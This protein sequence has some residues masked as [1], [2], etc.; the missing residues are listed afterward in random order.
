MNQH[1]MKLIR[2]VGMLTLLAA[3]SVLSGPVLVQGAAEES[4]T[5]LEEVTVSASRLRQ[6]TGYE[7]PTPVT[8]LT[9]QDME[10]RGSTNI[11][12]L[13]NEVPSFSGTM[14]PTST[15]LNSRQNGRNGLDIRGLGT[16]RNLVLVNGRRFV[17]F[18]EFG[19]VDINSIPSVAIKRVEIVTGGA[20]AAWG[21]DAVSGVINII[22]DDELEGTKVEAQYGQAGEGDNENYRISAALGHHFSDNRGHFMLAVEHFDTKGIPESFERDWAQEHWGFLSNPA[23]TGPNDGIPAFR[24]APDSKLFIGSP[25]GVTLPGGPVGN[26]E[27]FPDGSFGERALGVIGGAL[28][29]GGSGAYLVDRLAIAIPSD[30]TAVFGTLSYDISD[31]ARFFAEASYTEASSLGRFVDAFRFGVFVNSGNP[32]IPAELQATM[33]ETGTPGLVLFRTF[34]EFPPAGSDSKNTNKRIL[35]G[36][37]GNFGTDDNWWYE[38]YAQYGENQFNQTYVHNWLAGNINQAAL[39]VIDPITGEPVC[40][41][42][43]GGANG[44]PGCVPLNM[45]GKGSPSQAAIDYITQPFGFSK[46]KIKQTVIAFTV[47]GDIFEGWAGPIAAAF[48]AE[49]RDESLTRVVDEKSQNFEWR[50]INAQPLSGSY[51]VKE[52]FTEFNVPIVSGDQKLDV[53]AAV[54]WADYSTV[55]STVSWKGGLVWEPTD[56]LR[57]RASISQDIRAPSIGETFLEALLLFGTVNNPATGTA[58]FHEVINTGNENLSEETS[59]TQT[60][61]F[62]WSPENI[63]FQFSIDWYNIDVEDAIGQ[64]TNQQIVDN[65][66]DAGLAVFCDLIEFNATGNITRITNKLLNLGTFEFE[67]IDINANYSVEAGPGT[68][69]LNLAAN[70]R[71]KQKIAPSG[72]TPIDV[73]GEVGG[74]NTVG[75]PDWRANLRATY[76]LE[77]WGLYGQL[78]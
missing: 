47:G 37:D 2:S 68:F 34:E 64:I 57:F 70:H 12:D 7:S 24:F 28:M 78:R 6:V 44:A 20:S 53:N 66:F 73:V 36:V 13:I 26:L 40:A 4:E 48:G 52:L 31:N 39:V 15:V 32:F 16:N 30:R 38:A 62:V 71:I 18:E 27:F 33:D 9:T 1:A 77:N 35:A 21:S 14:T 5:L 25:N 60:L 76:D 54:R 59:I 51:D 41:A 11:A 65:C 42:N 63:N 75:A 22:F 69:G 29:E 74:V 61:G 8:M 55:G 58:D 46:T 43:A 19:T 3:F 72:G 10:A 49:Y 56:S 50:I 23:D 17:P 67:G 45:F